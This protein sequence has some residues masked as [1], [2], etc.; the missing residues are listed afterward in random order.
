[1]SGRGGGRR[2]IGEVTTPNAA[3][4]R[5]MSRGRWQ[6]PAEGDGG[7]RPRPFRWPGGGG[8]RG[9]S[10]GRGSREIGE[11]IT[12]QANC[13]CISARDAVRGRGAAARA[14]RQQWR[15]AGAGCT[16]G[17]PGA[18]KGNR[19][20]FKHGRYTA[21][22]IANRREVAALF[23]PCALWLT[24]RRAEGVQSPLTITDILATNRPSVL[25]SH[26]AERGPSTLSKSLQR[27]VRRPRRLV[28]FRM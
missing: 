27:G 28:R 13:T 4:P 19:N 25:S 21:Q 15:M 10:G 26:G 9:A 11:S 24:R 12:W 16:V 23:A 7:A 20:A 6:G 8:R 14:S 3:A 2:L 18:P 22:A 5:S 17:H 1:M